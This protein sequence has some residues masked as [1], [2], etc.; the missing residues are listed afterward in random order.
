ME[1]CTDLLQIFCGCFQDGPLPSLIKSGCYPFFLWNFWKFCAIFGKFLKIIFLKDHLPE[2]IH[3]F[4]L[5]SPQRTLFL[6]YFVIYIYSFNNRSLFNPFLTTPMF[7][8]I[9]GNIVQYFPILI[10]FS[11]KPLTRNHSYIK[12][13]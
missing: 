11:L 3:T 9:M 12:V 13:N 4:G 1:L 7:N 10:F 6:V 5:E 2:I 8:G